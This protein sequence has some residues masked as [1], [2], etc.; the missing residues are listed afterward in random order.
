MMQKLS[1]IT[2]NYNN[3]AGLQKTIES[4]VT[5]TS[6]DFEYIV[7]DGGS[8]D[9][10]TEVI[11]RYEDKITYWVSEPDRGIYH[12][13]NKGILQAKGKY[14]HF[15]NSGDYLIDRHV[16]EQMLHEM[17]DCS[18]LYG[19]KI[20][21]INGKLVTQKSYAGRPITLLDMYRSTIFHASAYIKRS[22]FDQYGLYDESLKIVSDWKF[23]LI[24]VGLHNEKVAYRDI[25]VVWFDNQG[26]SST[27]T[28]LDQKERAQV[29][30]QV[31]PK[32]IL[33]DYQE[34]ALDT[35]I[36]RRLKRNKLIWFLILNL[37]RVLFHLDRL[38]ASK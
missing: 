1:I 3:A 16:T 8:T 15:L 32:S 33:L 30:Q 14:C 28:A 22:L 18:I 21:E 9:G 26:I 17:P 5:Q 24:T 4:V 7:V 34:F 37:Y 20:R 23:Y 36:I 13:M 6:A 31:L 25:D 2:I 10:S 19:N 11:R 27:D 35:V 29:L 12:A 38:L